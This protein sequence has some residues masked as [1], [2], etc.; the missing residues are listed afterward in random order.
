MKSRT[1][2]RETLKC[3]TLA[4]KIEEGWPRNASKRWKIQDDGFFQ[5]L[6]EEHHP[7]DICCPVRTFWVF[8]LQN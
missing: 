6:Q 2:V 1:K 7:A 5:R 8:E 3:H 4:L